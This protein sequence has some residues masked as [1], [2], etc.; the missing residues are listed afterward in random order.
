MT[1]RAVVLAGLVFAAVASADVAVPPQPVDEADPSSLAQKIKL[2]GRVILHRLLFQTGRPELLPEAT[3][4]LESIRK[5]LVADPTLR[6]RIEG[7][8]D[9]RGATEWNQ[10]LS[11]QRASAVLGWLVDH[12]I[13]TARLEALGVGK[14]RPVATNQ[15]EVGRSANR[16]VE[17]VKLGR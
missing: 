6:L 7:H 3:P 16:R 11:S 5:L 13:A 8:T 2:D 10:L 1:K 9:G 17:L 14:S 4:I 15:S 12:G